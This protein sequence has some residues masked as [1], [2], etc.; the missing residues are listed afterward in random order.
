[1]S[2]AFLPGNGFDT[3][4]TQDKVLVSMDGTV[5]CGGFNLQWAWSSGH[6]AGLLL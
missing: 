3:Y 5:D 6:L 4:E 2:D 1:M